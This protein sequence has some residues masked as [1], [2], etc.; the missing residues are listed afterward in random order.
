M[1]RSSQVLPGCPIS[2]LEQ[3]AI[4]FLELGGLSGHGA[5]PQAGLVPLAHCSTAV[6][7]PE[8]LPTRNRA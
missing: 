1:E 4:W 5:S 8:Q 3:F 2:P 6:L 7:G